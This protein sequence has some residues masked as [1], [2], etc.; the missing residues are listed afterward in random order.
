MTVAEAQRRVDSRELTGWIA[1]DCIEP[2][3]PERFDIQL[4]ILCDIVARSHGARNSKP[5][6]YMPVFISRPRQTD[7]EMQA[8]L[9]TVK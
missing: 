5:A 2:I 4:A 1:T 7:A 8:I 9:R 6:D 3:G